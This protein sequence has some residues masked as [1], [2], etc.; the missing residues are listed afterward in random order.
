[1]FVLP[2]NEITYFLGTG[3]YDRYTSFRD[4]NYSDIG[5]L[6]LLYY[7]GFL[8]IFLFLIFEINLLKTSFYNKGYKS[9]FMGLLMLLLITNIKGLTTL[10]IIAFLY[11]D[12][13]SKNKIH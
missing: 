13:S 9:V 7:S 1:M 8:G 5:Y 12:I 11:L 2:K 10:A 4:F 6:R 3:I